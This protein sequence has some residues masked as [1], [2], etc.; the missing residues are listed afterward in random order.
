MDSKCLV[1]VQLVA[2]RV[3]L[4]LFIYLFIYL[5]R[6]SHQA[7]E[8]SG[9]LIIEFQNEGDKSTW[10]NGL[11]KATYQASVRMFLRHKCLQN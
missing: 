11:V 9:T 1:V 2:F 6:I 5:W 7:L 3:T 10:L 4:F 8:S